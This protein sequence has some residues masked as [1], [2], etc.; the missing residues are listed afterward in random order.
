VGTR[1]SSITKRLVSMGATVSLRCAISWS[2]RM[3][4]G[5]W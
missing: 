5:V 1:R 2:E 3:I 4:T